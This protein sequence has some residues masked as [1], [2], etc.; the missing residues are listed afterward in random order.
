MKVLI[1]GAAGM[2]GHKLYQSLESNFD[3]Y[4]T[5]RSGYEAVEKFGIF[6]KEKIIAR[7]EAMDED[8]VERAIQK[9][10]P[11]CIVNAIGVIKQDASAGD[12]PSMTAAN[13]SFPKLLDRLAGGETRVITIST[14]CVFDGW[15]GCYSETD[16]PDA[17][18]PYGKSKLQGEL[19]GKN[20]LTIRT[21]LIGREL[22]SSHSLVE[23]FLSHRGG[24]VD[25]YVN[26]IY[27]G[28]PT[29][30]FS[31]IISGLITRRADL[32]GVYHISSD[33]ISKFELLSLTNEAYEA[34][35][36]IE[37]CT[38][39]TIDRS[40]DSSRFRTRTGFAPAPWQQMIRQMAAD[41]T[42]YDEIRSR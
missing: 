24:Q 2:L 29:I 16:V 33:P 40:L 41:N 22:D 7:I 37:P 32:E 31:E 19:T 34:G 18:D 20:R 36:K 17:T 25:G 39:V 30:V 14:D 23:W 3:V 4:G 5:V 11:D 35:V 15:R 12:G 13:A 27:S 21:S 6:Q 8:S 1:F 10:R 26:A 42:P 38:A 9:V 28:F